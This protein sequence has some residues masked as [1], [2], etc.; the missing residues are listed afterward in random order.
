MKKNISKIIA[1]CLSAAM[2][3]GLAYTLGAQQA[4]AENSDESDVTLDSIMGNK[5][6]DKDETVYVIAAADGNVNKVIV[7]DWVKN[8]LGSATVEDKTNLKDVET[9]KS[10]IAYT[11]GEDDMRVWDANGEDLYYKGTSDKSLPVDVSIS[12]KL[13]GQEI[14]ADELAGKSGKV[15]IAFNYKNNEERTVTINGVQDEIYV[16][17]AMISGLKLDNE[18]FSNVT[19]SNGKLINDGDR[20]FVMGFAFPGLNDSLSLTEDKVAF[21][22]TVEISADVTDF[23]L[24][25]TLTV[26]A[27]GTFGEIDTDQFKSVDDISSA[28]S[29]M[30]SATQQLAD[31]TSDL[32]DGIATLLDKSSVLIDGVSELA[33]GA[34]SISDGSTQLY[35]GS[36]SLVSGAN[37][38]NG[39]LNELNTKSEELVAGSEQVFNTMLSTATAQIKA[40]GVNCPDLTIDNYKTVLGN[41][42]S[43]SSPEGARKL[44]YSTALSQV[45]A[46]VN[47]QE[48]TIR[49]KVTQVVSEQVYAGILETQGIT[50]EQYD[51]GVAAGQ[52]N[53][54]TQQAVSAAYEEQMSSADVTA[55]ID[56]SVAEQKQALIDSK[57]Q[58]PEVTS[59]IEAAVAAASQSGSSAVTQLIEQLDSYNTY[60][61]GVLQYTGAVG[62]AYQGSNQV[63]E[64]AK[65]LNGGIYNLSSGATELLNGVISLKDGSA[66]L[67]DGVTQLKDGATQLD[68]GMQEFNNTINNELGNMDLSQLNNIAARI[69]AISDV[70]NDYQSFGGIADGMDGEVKFV[71]KTDSIGE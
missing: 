58:S 56:A 1:V 51:A 30:T 45:T 32:Y 22:E 10:D 52:I 43:A 19:V 63:A 2:L 29:Q 41:L 47:A 50:K 64:G 38:L 17:F 5:N 59:Q 20:S 54:E 62:Q 12:Y 33:A 23:E 21:P 7:S 67:I 39:G 24:D 34:Q 31:G 11:L 42:A 70:S 35:T 66:T 68:S 61:Q 48:A 49:T 18:K 28:L 15:D 46:G 25:T 9:T 44:A 60:Y 57:M 26:A 69:E 36:Q 37:Q 4:T 65:Q 8:P 14:S 40:A 71:Y 16:P 27:N 3:C 6:V 55:K 13:D 53:E